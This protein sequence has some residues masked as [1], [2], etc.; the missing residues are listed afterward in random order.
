MVQLDA[1]T[2]ELAMRG[3]FRYDQKKGKYFAA[4]EAGWEKEKRIAAGRRQLAVPAE[5]V[6]SF[7]AEE[8]KMVDGLLKK[9]VEKAAKK[10]ASEE[11]PKKRKAEEEG[12]AEEEEKPK[13]KKKPVEEEEEED[14]D[15][16]LFG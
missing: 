1:R 13:K 10:G 2:H 14:V 16:D 5:T 12:E 9:L 4:G 7:L 8:E 6:E 3:G 15:F 11:A